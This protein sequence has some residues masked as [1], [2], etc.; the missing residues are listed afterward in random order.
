MATPSSDSDG[1]PETP[2]EKE[3]IKYRSTRKTLLQANNNVRQH[4]YRSPPLHRETSFAGAKRLERSNF[5][6]RVPAAEKTNI[7]YKRD[8]NAS[9]RIHQEES[10]L[11]FPLEEENG[12]LR[13]TPECLEFQL[14][15]TDHSSLEAMKP[16]RQEIVLQNVSNYTVSFVVL[17]T[18]S[19]AFSVACPRKKPFLCA[20]MQ[21]RVQ[22]SFCA[23]V[24]EP[25]LDFIKVVVSIRSIEHSAAAYNRLHSY[26]GRRFQDSLVLKRIPVRA[27]WHCRVGV[28]NHVASSTAESNG[29][30]E[31]QKGGGFAPLSI[32]SRLDFGPT[33]VG[34]VRQ[35]RLVL[36]PALWAPLEFT[37][38]LTKRTRAF[39]VKPQKGVIGTREPAA[40]WLQFAPRLHAEYTEDLLVLLGPNNTPHRVT[41]LGNGVPLHIAGQSLLI[42]RNSCKMLESSPQLDPSKGSEEK[43]ASTSSAEEINCGQPLGQLADISPGDRNTGEQ[44]AA[45]SCV[46]WPGATYNIDLTAG[47]TPHASAPYHLKGPSRRNEC[48]TK[49]GNYVVAAAN[50]IQRFD[51]NKCGEG[52]VSKQSLDERW[53]ELVAVLRGQKLGTHTVKGAALPSD[54]A[55]QKIQLKRAEEAQR[56]IRLLQ[57]QDRSR[58]SC[59]YAGAPVAPSR[60]AFQ[61]TSDTTSCS[62]DNGPMLR[63]LWRSELVTRFHQAAATVV[64]RAR[65][66]RRLEAIRSWI[67]SHALR[68]ETNEG[69]VQDKP[70]QNSQSNCANNSRRE[71][72]RN[73]EKRCQQG[74]SSHPDT[75]QQGGSLVNNLSRY[76]SSTAL[77]TPSGVEGSA[78]AGFAETP[79]VLQGQDSHSSSDENRWKVQLV[80]PRLSLPADS[81]G[82][83]QWQNIPGP[84][85]WGKENL[86]V[87][88]LFICMQHSA[89]LLPLSKL[90]ADV[91]RLKEE[92]VITCTGGLEVTDTDL[93]QSLLEA[94]PPLIDDKPWVR[95]TPSSTHVLDD[96]K[97]SVIM[98]SRSQG[99]YEALDNVAILPP[100]DPNSLATLAWRFVASVAP[101]SSACMQLP[102]IVET[103][104][105]YTFLQVRTGDNSVSLPQP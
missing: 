7:Q 4:A 93:L 20:G 86:N 41:L 62:Q 5:P 26:Q 76:Q 53:A 11:A 64:L 19:K 33:K 101:Y 27:V 72:E 98:R 39:S 97:T 50:V 10:F 68:E 70:Q 35:R 51:G 73:F 14:D 102:P 77:S 31:C 63:Q 3:H 59:T 18:L 79:T 38:E 44:M 74:T 71:Q 89:P 29:K 47:A 34:S 88:E 84:D 94:T 99:I 55:V 52:A 43:H 90:D 60:T 25:Q 57:V 6:H 8:P 2:D 65:M 82:E 32:V 56:M 83:W 12:V 49:G 75:S 91:F 78:M 69:R 67:R 28:E 92:E 85:F 105:A 36:P 9:H 17:P 16:L 103:D 13:A 48:T 61:N 37:V 100:E 45:E 23:D 95:C 80:P 66:A 87:A 40:L 81:S 46:E 24:C 15:C 58:S 1:P 96:A 54:A 22:I 104:L 42:S 21:Q 30:Y